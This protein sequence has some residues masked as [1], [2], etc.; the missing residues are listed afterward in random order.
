MKKLSFLIILLFSISCSHSSLDNTCQQRRAAFDVG[1]GSTRIMIARVDLCKKKVE[2]VLYEN[3][4]AVPYRETLVN[5]ELDAKTMQQGELLIQEHLKKAKEFKVTKVLAVGTEVFRKA[6]NGKAFV[7]KLKADLDFDLRIIDQEYEALL[8]FTGVV[9]RTGENPED[10]LVWDMGGGSTQIV[11][12]S[13]ENFNY[14]FPKLGSVSFKEFVVKDIQKKNPKKV[15]SPNPISSKQAKLAEKKTVAQLKLN[16]VPAWLSAA[17]KVYG[18][19]GVHYYSIRG[20]INKDQ[21]LYTSE[22]LIAALAK[23]LNKKDEEIGGKYA[24]TEVTNLILV[25]SMMN[26]MNLKEVHTLKVNLTEALL[27]Q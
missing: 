14:Y 25:K 19:G 18:I 20:Q 17:K 23:Q 4:E 2:E 3:E 10:I 12:K 6:S 9:V 26:A 21:D 5:D 15:L 1:S 11:S 16:K 13:G 7:D 8:G 27:F 24:S 22:E